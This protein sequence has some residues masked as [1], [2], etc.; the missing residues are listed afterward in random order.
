MAAACPANPNTR[1]FQ[2][3]MKSL[4]PV[5]AP[6]APGSVFPPAQH[7]AWAKCLPWQSCRRAWQARA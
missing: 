2:S 1:M 6:Y 3:T 4:A 7:G 5:A